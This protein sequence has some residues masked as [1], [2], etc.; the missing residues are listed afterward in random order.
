MLNYTWFEDNFGDLIEDV[1]KEGNILVIETPYGR[2]KIMPEHR[3][4][5][6]KKLHD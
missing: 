1:Y 6:R 4:P 5:R 3:K 2:V